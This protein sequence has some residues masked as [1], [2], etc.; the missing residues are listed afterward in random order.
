[1]ALPPRPSATV[2]MSTTSAWVSQVEIA[3]DRTYQTGEKR[4]LGSVLTA[5]DSGGVRYVDMTCVIVL[6]FVVAMATPYISRDFRLHE[7]LVVSGV[8]TALFT[9]MRF[10]LWQIRRW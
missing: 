9:G 7:R 3:E 10:F 5:Q 1:M 8:A 2:R 4:H 6:L